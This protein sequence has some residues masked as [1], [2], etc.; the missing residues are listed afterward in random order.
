MEEKGLQ[1]VDDPSTLFIT[2]REGI[3]PPGV[4]I[5]PVFEGSRVFLVEIQALTI[6]AKAALT[7]VYSEKIDS[8]RVSRIAAVLEKRVGLRFSDQDIYVNVAG[9]VKLTES[10]IDAGL[11][12]ALYSARTDIAIPSQSVITGEI[13]LA[14][15]IRPVA[16]TAQRIKTARS[17]GFQ[18]VF[19]PESDTDSTCIRDI[20]SLIQKIFGQPSVHQPA[21]GNTTAG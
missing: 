19:A 7:R 1:A 3:V 16:R 8:A 20:K 18:Q 6:P 4:A 2:R 9:G 13:S 14:G 5:V 11:A 17:M 12:A 10:A 21:E 15:E